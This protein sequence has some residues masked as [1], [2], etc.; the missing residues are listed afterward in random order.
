M[1]KIHSNH[2]SV[3][4]QILACYRDTRTGMQV[5]PSTEKMHM[6]VQRLSP[7]KISQVLVSLAL[8]PARFFWYAI[9]LMCSQKLFSPL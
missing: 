9:Y 7:G 6:L 2:F 5:S 1:A 3:L 8:L 4:P